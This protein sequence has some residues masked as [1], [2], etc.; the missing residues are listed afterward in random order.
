[1]NEMIP[2]SRFGEANGSP[3]SVLDSVANNCSPEQ[4]R[5]MAASLLRLADA[6]D[7]RWQPPSGNGM[8]RWPSLLSR[9]EREAYNLAQ[10]AREEYQRRRSR[11]EHLPASILAEPAWDMLLEL[12]QQHAGGAKVSTKS[13]CIASCCPTTTA[14][15][16]I[17][18]LEDAGLVHR[19]ASEYD[20]RVT[21]IGLTEEGV[22]AM[23]GYLMD[24]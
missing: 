7:Q 10:K 13:L 5:D 11:A 21:F 6:I 12:F 1:M 16:Y 22:L 24:R 17:S 4:I 9:I 19:T 15:R 23:G 8:F 3:Q 18:E 14:L 2:D 20:K